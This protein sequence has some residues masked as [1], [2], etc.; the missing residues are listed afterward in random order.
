MGRNSMKVLGASN[1]SN[2][3]RVENDFYS[4]DPIA[5]EGLLKEIPRLN[6]RIWECACGQGHLSKV[7]EKY[8]YRV[9]STDLI[10][11]GYGKGGIDFLKREKLWKGD[12]L[13]NPPYIHA[14]E[15]IRKGLQLVPN[16][17]KVIMFLK[18]LFLEGKK[19]KSLFAEFPPKVI[20]VSS[21]RIACSRNGIDTPGKGKAVA[22]AWFIWE[23]GFKG[24]TI[25]KWFN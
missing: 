9:K 24:G 18:L 15:F 6:S 1:L 25:V 14:E 12:I 21:S 11:R 13:T 2:R 10:D 17:N 5:L 16:G 22:Y 19:K 7:L 23:K 20:Y 8:N 4:T 3:D